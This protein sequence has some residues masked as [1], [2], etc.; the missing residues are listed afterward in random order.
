VFLY[1]NGYSSTHIPNDLDDL[2]ASVLWLRDCY[3]VLYKC[4]SLIVLYFET[5][6]TREFIYLVETLDYYGI[7]L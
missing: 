5:F 3:Y 6:G 2:D 1:L 4:V 7:I